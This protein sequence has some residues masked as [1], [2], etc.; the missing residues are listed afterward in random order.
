[1]NVQRTVLGLVAAVALLGGC[2]G[3]EHD[4]HSTTADRV[5]NVAMRDIAYDPAAVTVKAGETVR[6][7][8]N[9]EGKLPHDAFIGDEAAQVEHEKEMREADADGKGGGHDAHGIVVDPGDIGSLTYTFKA[10]DML[11]I[12]CHQVGHYAAGMKVALT[13]T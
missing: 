11:I 8:F 3:G 10:G 9:N 7:V 1:M 13:V 12:G 4:S 6:F 5:V 2:G